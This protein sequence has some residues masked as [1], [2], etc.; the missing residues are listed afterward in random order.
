MLGHSGSINHKVDIFIPFLSLPPSIP[1]LAPSHS[2]Y[3]MPQ[4]VSQLVW[5]TDTDSAGKGRETE[6]KLTA[7]EPEAAAA[8]A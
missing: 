8:A 2:A 6:R 3:Q 5:Q 7:D 1:Y 4:K